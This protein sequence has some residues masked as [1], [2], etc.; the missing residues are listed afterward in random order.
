MV[1]QRFDLVTSFLTRHDLFF[2][3]R[4][5]KDEHS[6]KVSLRTVPLR[7]YSWFY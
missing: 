5:Y 7:V 3:S 4:F 2:L 1:L 6:D